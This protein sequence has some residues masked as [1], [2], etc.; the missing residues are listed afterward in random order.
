MRIQ[1]H[2]ICP[3]FTSPLQVIRGHVKHSF[4][5]SNTW[6]GGGVLG[7]GRGLVIKNIPEREKREV[8]ERMKDF[9]EGMNKLTRMTSRVKLTL[10]NIHGR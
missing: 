8:E 6:G 7:R 3:Y 2:K 4:H 1:A 9:E 5:L 10:K